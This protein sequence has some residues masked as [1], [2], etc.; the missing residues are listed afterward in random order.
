MAT[1]GDEYGLCTYPDTRTGESIVILLAR[2]W[3]AELMLT[4]GDE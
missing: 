3:R 4:E 1:D 2:L